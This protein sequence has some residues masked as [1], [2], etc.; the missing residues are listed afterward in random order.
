MSIF[1]KNIEAVYG[2]TAGK[3][4]TKSQVPPINFNALEESSLVDYTISGNMEQDASQQYTLSGTSP[5]DFISDTTPLSSWELDGN[6]TQASSQEYSLTGTSPLS[7][8]S[9]TTTLATWNVNGNMVQAS[10]QEYTISG[11]SPITFQSDAMDIAYNIEGQMTQTGTPTPS[12][13]IQPEECGDRTA[14]LLPIEQP[15]TVD[16][17]R[18]VFNDS[19]DFDGESITIKTNSGMS[20]AFVDK[21]GDT[22]FN[23]TV[24][25]NIAKTV[26]TPNGL[27]A[28]RIWKGEAVTGMEIML[29]SGSTA[30][31]YEPYGYAL[32]ISCGG[33]TSTIYLTEPL[34][35]IGDYTDS[36]ES[37]GTVT[38]KVRQLVLTGQE[39]WTEAGDGN[40]YIALT[41]NQGVAW[42]QVLSTHFTRY[43]VQTNGGLL[44]FVN[45]NVDF[46]T[47]EE[48]KTYLV[49]QY[50]AGTPV[51]VWYVLANPVTETITTPTITAIQ[52]SNTLTVDTTLPPSNISITTNS[53]VYPSNPIVPQECG[54]R[55]NNLFNSASV[56]AGR[57]NQTTGNIEYSSDTTIHDISINSISFST[58]ATWR[59]FVTDFIQTSNR[60]AVAIGSFVGSDG[61][62][63]NAYQYAYAQD[64]SFLGFIAAGSNAPEGTQY[65]RVSF[66]CNVIVTNAVVTNIMLNTGSTALPYEPYGYKCPITCGGQTQTV[67][68]TEPLRKI[69]DYEDSVESDGTVTRRVKKLVLTGEERWY[70]YS[71]GSIQQYYTQGKN[72]GGVAISSAYSTIAPYGMTANTRTGEYGCYTVTNGAEIAFQMYG[73]ITDFPNAD[74]WKTYLVQQYAAG[75]PVCFWYVLETPTTESFTAPTITTSIGNNTLT[76]DTTLTPSSI[77]IT[78]TSGVWPSNPII[79]EECGDRTWNLFDYKTVYASYIDADGNISTKSNY[80]TSWNSFTNDQI[81]KTLTIS[82]YAAQVSSSYI[83]VQGQIDGEYITGDAITA[84]NTGFSQIT[85]TPTSTSDRWRITYGSG[86]FDIVVNQVMIAEGSTRQDYEPY[87]YK[88]P[89][90][91]GGQ[92]QTIYLNEPI[93]KIGTY[94]DTVASDGTVTRLVKKVVLTGQETWNESQ[95]GTNTFRG[96]TPVS[97]VM[98]GAK[99]YCTHTIYVS[100]GFSN[101]IQ[102]AGVLDVR[103]FLHLDRSIANDLTEFK[104]YLAQQYANGNPV[105]VW[106]V[107]NTATTE[108]ITPPTLNTTIGNNTLTTSTTLSPSSITITTSSGVWPKNPIQLVEC[109]DYIS[110][111]TYAGKYQIQIIENGSYY[112]IYLDQP[113][114][115]IGNYSDTVNAD[116]T[117]SRRIKKFI[118]TGTE[119]WQYLASNTHGLYNYYFGIVPE[120]DFAVKN[121]V[122]CTHYPRGTKVFADETDECVYNGY[123]GQNIY[124]R[125]TID[126]VTDFKEF[127]ANQYSAG[128]PV[129]IWYV[130][131]TP[132]T[133]TITVPDI[134]THS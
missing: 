35:K 26:E 120:K 121:T 96:V 134:Y 4:D 131:E 72:I 10:S 116:G 102:L 113:I 114:R 74:A 31:P 1:D 125:S 11:T 99:G 38:R 71:T 23:G 28:L 60:L 18:Y 67:Y 103:L 93:R 81:G 105:T 94:S 112:Y 95:S 97:E 2:R 29:N 89:I 107:L 123:N 119:R 54:D 21:N 91:V 77:S 124:I 20:V 110:S 24:S 7:F 65:I 68:L 86:S 115:K 98:S 43:Q 92:T 61:S 53:S 36:V 33:T 56:S 78:T 126:N 106:Y 76:A 34:R 52:G 127:L 25:A 14:N 51:T 8:I 3:I 85:V 129:I 58:S 122:I 41:P 13:P 117:V 88:L 46:D 87:G 82:M 80:I 44:W 128:T 9:D 19:F 109:G 83:R 111:G 90:T 50:A 37:D 66:Q 133:E 6:M 62:T 130:L 63:F 57:I 39:N 27:S 84:N 45:A 49:A 69:G 104:A 40:I 101:D 22:I 16:T 17:A 70:T 32:P 59:G 55:T 73:S 108:T 5:L 12:V 118:V 42:T 48:C 79:P 30:L 100:T 75:T 15:I 64:K 47:A 132:E